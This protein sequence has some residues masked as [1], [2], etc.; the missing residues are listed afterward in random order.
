MGS[1]FRSLRWRI[2]AWHAFILVLVIGLFGGMLQWEMT[3]AHWDGVD[4]ELVSAARVLEGALR[5]API[6][7][8]NSLSQ[9]IAMPPGPRLPAWKKESAN[10]SVR[11]PNSRPSRPMRPDRDGSIVP[12]SESLSERSEIDWGAISPDTSIPESID[13][14]ERLLVLPDSLPQQLGRRVS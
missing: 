9:D 1:W 12:R 2:Q 4:E 14:W 10:K 11:S 6:P 7:I 13:D 8:L 3:R 5:L